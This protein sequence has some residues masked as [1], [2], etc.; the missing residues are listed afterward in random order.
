MALTVTNPDKAFIAALGPFKLEIVPCTGVLNDD[1]YTS[2]L[3]TVIACWAFPAADAGLTSTNQ[4][5]T[6]SGKLITVRDPAVTAQTLVIL[7]F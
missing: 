5:A 4:S 6:F 2:K 3:V 7:G 1:T